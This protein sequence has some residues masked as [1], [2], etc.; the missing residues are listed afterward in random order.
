MT[1]ICHKGIVIKNINYSDNHKILTI[2]IKSM[3]KISCI[4]K[5]ARKGKGPLK[6]SIEPFSFSEF[7]FFHVRGLPLVVESN[8][9]TL[10]YKWRSDPILSAYA[11][12]WMELI[13]KLI[14]E[15]EP[16]HQLYNWL[17]VAIHKIEKLDPDLLTVILE[18]KILDVAGY[19]PVLDQC[20]GC[21]SKQKLIA[22]SIEQGGVLC[23]DCR[24]LES[25]SAIILDHETIELFLMLQSTQAD[26]YIDPHLFSSSLEVISDIL[27][28]F[29][30]EHIPITF[31]SRGVLMQI[32]KNLNALISR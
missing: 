3:G 23:E 15:K 1:Y 28:R 26:T 30:A 4:A 31:K 18:L 29:I 25:T 9:L 32:K 6:S 11:Y 13:D 5:Y 10:D 19:R 24:T 27:K 22:I 20:L 12:Y 2:F 21:G 16:L 8:L 17:V 7:R 14:P